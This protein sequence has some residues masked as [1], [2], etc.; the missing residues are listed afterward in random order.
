MSL[1][2]CGVGKTSPRASIFLYSLG[3]QDYL[4]LME[5]RLPFKLVIG[6]MRFVSLAIFSPKKTQ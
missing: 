2:L 5:S 3:F 6:G 1:C 4:V